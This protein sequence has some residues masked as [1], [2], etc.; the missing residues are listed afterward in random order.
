MQDV[1][2]PAGLPYFYCLHDVWCRIDPLSHVFIFPAIGP[3]D[4]HPYPAPHLQ[5]MLIVYFHK[6]CC[7][8][9]IDCKCF[10]ETVLFPSAG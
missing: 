7:Q 3:T 10:S 5:N 4:L 6:V 9:T 2:N 8:S 1:I